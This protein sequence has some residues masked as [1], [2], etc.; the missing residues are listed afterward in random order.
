M[1]EIVN[2]P[3]LINLIAASTGVEPTVAR[4]FLHEFFATIENGLNSDGRVSIKGVGEF[5]KM[6]EQ[7][8]PVK[9]LADKDLAEVANAPFSAFE[10]VELNDSVSETDLSEPQEDQPEPEV[11]QPE[12]EVEQSEY[13]VELPEPEVEQSEPEVEQSEPEVEQPEPEVEQS[14][15]EVEQSVTTPITHIIE[16]TD[17]SD[18]S[19]ASDT[20]DTSDDVPDAPAPTHRGLYFAVGILAGLILGLVLGYFAGKTMAEIGTMPTIDTP[21]EIAA[22]DTVTP[23]VETQQL[24]ATPQPQPEQKEPIYDTVSGTRYLSIIALDH[25]GKKN[26]WVFIYEANKD[27]IKDPNNIPTGTKVRVPDK[28]EFAEATT[29][30]TDEKAQR[31]L[32]KYAK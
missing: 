5:V 13:E 20:P 2:L 21:T 6:P 10:A 1:N 15:P 27:I 31:L 28:E 17:T 32:N 12:P 16:P 26:Y 9:F 3:K 8:N 29:A 18:T 11:E 14:E 19:D 25:Y 23:P 4:R 30:A 7:A 22:T 24:A